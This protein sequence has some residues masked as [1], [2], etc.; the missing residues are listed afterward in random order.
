MKYLA[1]ALL[2]L[3]LIGGPAA[4]FGPIVDLPTLTF[5]D[6]GSTLSTKGCTPAQGTPMPCDE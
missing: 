1:P 2:I 6:S 3:S 5:P 4:A